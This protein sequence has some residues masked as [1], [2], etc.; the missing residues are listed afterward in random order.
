MKNSILII[1]FLTL[2]VYTPKAFG[3][4]SAHIELPPPAGYDVQRMYDKEGNLLFYDSTEVKED[5]HTHNNAEFDSL[6]GMLK[7]QNRSI[8]Y[9]I[10]FPRDSFSF[11]FQ[12]PQR[13][14]EYAPR[15][16]FD[17]DI[18]SFDSLLKD[19]EY[20]FSLSP[21]DSGAKKETEDPYYEY[22]GNQPEAE[23]F[24]DDDMWE[25]ERRMR[26]FHDRIIRDYREWEKDRGKQ[27][28]EVPQQEA[29]PAIKE[30]PAG[31]IDI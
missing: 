7:E 17:I 29:D 18:P 31:R 6:V 20:Y 2:A 16:E 24:P 19:F 12:L 5:M 27:G 28:S 21:A 23:P 11:S 14:L 3:Q 30:E 13:F 8:R 10:R 22:H 25:I 4:D 1:L 26:E 15:Y 9:S